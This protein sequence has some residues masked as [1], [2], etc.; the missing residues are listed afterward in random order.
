MASS[1][2][3]DDF[4]QEIH[5]RLLDNDP[6]ASSELA[7]KFLKRL[8]DWLKHKFSS[9]DEELICNAATDAILDYTS[10]PS[11]FNPTKLSLFGYL[12]MSAN[13]DL[14]NILEK[15][16]RRNGHQEKLV[17]QIFHEVIQP[18]LNSQIDLPE[19]S[20]LLIP[21]E[22]GTKQNIIT[23]ILEKEFP[24]PLDRQLL[25]LVLKK[26]S[27]TSEF[28]QILGI[29]DQDKNTQKKIVNRHKNRINKRI[30]RLRRRFRG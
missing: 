24:E 21:N 25:P 2:D 29:Q 9:V 30:E 6:T 5:Q 14:L 13:C 10:Y 28:I 4:E 19:D 15:E 27:K 22:Y 20:E 1:E 12:K 17:Q 26:R 3:F 16:K 11:R 7:R 8:L 23:Q 18:N